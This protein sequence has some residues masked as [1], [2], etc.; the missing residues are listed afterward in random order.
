MQVSFPIC[1]FFIRKEISLDKHPEVTYHLPWVTTI[2]L[3]YQIV[4]SVQKIFMKTV[5]IDIFC[6]LSTPERKHLERPMTSQIKA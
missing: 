5:N 4:E 6:T 2:E 1:K 3:K